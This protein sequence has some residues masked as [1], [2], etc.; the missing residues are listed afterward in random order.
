MEPDRLQKIETI[1]HKALDA[2]DNRRDG[3]LE[4]SCAGDEALRCEVESLLAQHKPAENFIE[5]PAFALTAMPPAQQ[6]RS[7]NS[8]QNPGLAGTEIG[9]FR[10]L[11]K[12]GGGGQGVVYEAEDLNLGRHVALK[13]LPEELIDD[14]RSLQRFRREARA[15]SALNHSNICTI[16]EV[17]EVEGRAF[18][19]MELLEGQTLKHAIS[20]KPIEI[21]TVLDLGIQIAAA[22]D[23][24]HATGIVHR[25]IKPANIFITRHGQAK[26][27]DFGLA[28]FAGNPLLRRN[29]SGAET[30]SQGPTQPGMV[31]GTLGYMSPEQIKGMD[32]DARTDLFSFGAVLYQMVTGVPPFRGETAAMIY[33]AILN[34]APVPM[35]RLNPGVPAKLEETII[36][37]LEKDRNLR[38]QSAAEL[39][40]DL[41]RIKRDSSSRDVISTTGYTSPASDFLDSIAVLPF[42][43]AGK[44]P[45]MEYLSDGITASIINNLSQV[46]RLRVVPRTT[47][48]GYKGRLSDLTLAVRELR[49]RVVLT[50]RVSQRGDNLTINVEL[51]DAERESQLWGQSYTGSSE[52]VLPIQTEIAT[53]IANR[54]KLPLNDEEKEQL[55]KRPTRSREAYHLLLKSMY[56]ANKLTPD[57]I[58]KGVDYARQ[59]IDIDP[60]YAEAWG[61]LAYSF[62]LLGFL[63][64]ASQNEMFARAKVAATKSLEIDDS[65]ADAHATLAYVR[66][67]YDWD[68]QGALQLLLRAIELG[69]N[70]AHGHYVYSQWFLTQKLYEE[71]ES[72][73]R[74]ALDIDPL[75]M[76]ISHHLTMVHY[77]SRHYDQAIEQF[78]E[79]VELY[80]PSG[81]GHLFLGFAYAQKCMWKEA[82]GE[83]EQGLKSANNDLRSEA[84]FGM[85][86]AMVGELVEARRI[87]DKLK[88]QLKPPGFLWAYPC[89]A[90]HAL[91]GEKDEAFACLDM[92]RQGHSVALPYIAIAHEFESLHDDPRFPDLVRRI[93]IPLA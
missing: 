48:F 74:L 25:D 66:L 31:I 67:V 3:V 55:A 28:K 71:A 42:E 88:Q 69:P 53:Q 85:V 81:P 61:A 84:G 2:D 23:V 57:G 24:A 38:Y 56:W 17:D 78:R 22:L 72:E 44:D 18:I 54:L 76:T 82:K 7:D 14:P 43:N 58:R 12:I 9:H 6:L 8:N 60:V 10:V 29:A 87:L 51:I 39:R 15:A 20:Q 77:F 16:Y 70:L 73:A 63:G 13:F 50:G 5:N 40:T 4:E 83:I 27:L 90:L 59:A 37:A 21:E 52:D 33:D 75:S 11:F 89:A 80:P 91:L 36:K 46:S 92:A 64:G 62:I 47:V 35:V 19:A 26:V 30:I 68:W 45:E 79:T 34:R 49:V 93:G 32:L 1:L 86:S 41:H 65:G